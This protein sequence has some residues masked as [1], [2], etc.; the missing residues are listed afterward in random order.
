MIKIQTEKVLDSNT[1]E[2]YKVTGIKAMESK[3]LPV[4][5]KLGYPMCYKQTAFCN[6]PRLVVQASEDRYESI[7]VGEVLA[8][9]QLDAAMWVINQ[10][11][12]RLMRINKL[13][14][15]K[16]AKWNGKVV[17]KT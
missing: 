3:D 7:C 5:Y 1:D 16:E 14:R 15:Q 4:P 10:C 9:D 8:P 11:G 6:I 13:I 17:F 12:E 2:A